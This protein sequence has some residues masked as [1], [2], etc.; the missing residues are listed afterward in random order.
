MVVFVVVM[1][2]V[3]IGMFNWVW[4]KNIC[5]YLKFVMIVMVVMVVVV[6]GIYN[7]VLGVGVGVLLSVLFFV[8][9]VL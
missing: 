8:C 7:L 3:L 5:V 2:M 1:I 9:W 6:V 4:F